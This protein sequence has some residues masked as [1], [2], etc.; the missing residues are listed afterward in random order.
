[1]EFI[2]YF[3]GAIPPEQRSYSV[4]H[5][6][7]TYEIR[8]YHPCVAASVSVEDIPQDQ[9]EG[10]KFDEIAFQKLAKYIGVIGQ[11]ENVVKGKEGEKISMTAPVGM[12]KGNGKKETGEKISMTAPVGM[13]K[14]KGEK[15]SMTAPVGQ[16]NQSEEG[17]TKTMSFY[18]PNKYKSKEDAPTPKDDVVKIVQVPEK[19]EAAI[20][21]SWNAGRKRCQD[22]AKELKGLLE[23]DGLSARGEWKFMGYNPPFCVPFLKRN[24]VMFELDKDQVEQAKFE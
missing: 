14:G 22:K 4:L 21:F 13:E 2:T 5:K 6:R 16:D 9:L 7:P 12:D 24:E 8:K 15:I 3:F 17:E 18:L 11:P 20:V 23:K 1:M 10:M 19:I